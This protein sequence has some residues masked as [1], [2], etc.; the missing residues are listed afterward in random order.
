MKRTL[1]IPLD[2]L[3]ARLSIQVSRCH[4]LTH[5]LAPTLQRASAW[6]QFKHPTFG[7]WKFIRLVDRYD[8]VYQQALRRL[9]DPT[10]SDVLL[11]LGCGV[12]QVVRQLLCDGVQASRVYGLDLEDHLVQLGYLL[13]RDKSTLDGRFVAG[14]MLDQRDGAVRQLHGKITL[15]HA[16]SF[17]HIFSWP[18]QVAIAVRIID[19]LQPGTKHALVFG[20]QV[21]T[22]RPGEMAGASSQ[23]YL[24]NQ[25]SF[26]KLWDEVGRLTKTRWTVQVETAKEKLEQIPG[27]SKEVRLTRYAVLQQ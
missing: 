8:C 10:T 11:D 16:S 24:H 5:D 4:S 2:F 14:N 12:G 13:F 15:V 27:F 26:Q 21:G 23:S 3:P 20:T 1:L 9:K 19:L 7:R 6:K 25:L 18:Q 17:W 22:T